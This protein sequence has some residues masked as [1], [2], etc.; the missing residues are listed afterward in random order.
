MKISSEEFGVLCYLA[1]MQSGE[2]IMDKSPTYIN[3]KRYLMMTGYE[4]FGALDP[5]NKAKVIEWSKRWGVELE[6]QFLQPQNH[7]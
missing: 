4:A 3:E 5:R 2:G 6:E 7:D 1:L